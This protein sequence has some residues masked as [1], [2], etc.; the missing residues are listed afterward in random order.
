M[1]VHG[2]QDLTTTVKFYMTSVFFEILLPL[3]C[4]VFSSV[5]PIAHIKIKFKVFVLEVFFH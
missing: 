4:Q 2:P 3:F 1:T 5:S